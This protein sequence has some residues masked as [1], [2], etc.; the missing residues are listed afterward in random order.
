MGIIPF[1]LQY[2][3]LESKSSL[4]P[5][6]IPLMLNSKIFS[7]KKILIIARGGIG[8][9]LMFTPTLKLLRKEFQN[10][11]IYMLVDSKGSNDILSINSNIKEVI[12]YDQSAKR[13]VEL[14]KFLVMLRRMH[15]DLAI[16]VHPGGLRS[17]LWAFNSGARIRIGFNIPLLKGL[18]P[19]LYT[20]LLKP[21]DELHDVE[22]NL[23]ILDSLGI[24]H[25][26]A[27]I[28]L[29]ISIPDDLK[30][31]ANEY[32]SRQG[33]KDKSKIIG[34]H[35]GSG[36]SQKWK[37]WPAQYFSEL[38]NMISSEW[39]TSVLIFGDHKEEDL[40]NNILSVVNESVKVVKITD[41][42]LM[43]TVALIGLCNAFIGND[44]G[45]MHIAASNKF[46]TFC[47]A[48]PTDVRKTG[49]YGPNTYI[50][51]SDLDCLFCYNFNTLNF[52]C[53]RNI[54]YKCLNELYPE[55]VFRN[56]SPT[57]SHV[58]S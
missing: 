9:V 24:N 52:K 2:K 27:S 38:I 54:N 26:D 3:E 13:L 56:I 10:S 50:V 34:F 47:I 31:S 29:S 21:N 40:I 17:A 15:F 39:E 20:H 33:F 16:V 58:L 57:L 22:Q 48:G 55:E 51:H 30:K 6:D 23:N 53:P 45:L 7:P 8:N 35:P 1:L 36:V 11:E 4:S 14:S 18:G 25:S 12:L 5:C 28:V 46:L 49:P 19:F 32:L 44:S 42:T 43:E 37:R 41:K